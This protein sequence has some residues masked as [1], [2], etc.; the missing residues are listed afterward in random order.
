MTTTKNQHIRNTTFAGLK[1]RRAF[2]FAEAL[3]ASTILAIIATTATLPFS[4]GTQSAKEAQKLERAVE[5]AESMMEEILA[6]PF[7]A[8]GQSAPTPGPDSGETVRLAY[9][10]IDDFS[11]YSESDQ[12]LRNYKGGAI[13]DPDVQGFW[14]QVSVDYVSYPDQQPGDTDSIMHVRVKVYYKSALQV[15]LDRVVTRDD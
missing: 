6:R 9:D 15:T 13:N 14:R 11:G 2:T 4:A 7:F 3:L 5:L 8:P 12:V 1:R 10:S